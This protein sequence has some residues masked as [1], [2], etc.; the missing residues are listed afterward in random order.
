MLNMEVHELVEE[1]CIEKSILRGLNATFLT[2]I[3]KFDDVDSLVKFKPIP[4]CN[5]I[6]IIISKVLANRIKSILP[7][8]ISQHQSS[9]AEGR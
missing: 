7:L 5:V 2:F 3:L 9:Y 4:L 8:L 1:S 6:Y